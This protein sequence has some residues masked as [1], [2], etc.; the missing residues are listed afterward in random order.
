M[1]PWNFIGLRCERKCSYFT[2][3]PLKLPLLDPLYPLLNSRRLA[4]P[5]PLENSPKSDSLAFVVYSTLASL[6]REYIDTDL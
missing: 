6:R 2:D 1:P 3:P 5:Y 4:F